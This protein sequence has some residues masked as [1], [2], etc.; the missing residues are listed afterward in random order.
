MMHTNIATIQ[1]AD[2]SEAEWA[3]ERSP[4]RDAV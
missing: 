3:P 1:P 2:C 4:T